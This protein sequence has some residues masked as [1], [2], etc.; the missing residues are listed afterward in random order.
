MKSC[1]LA[2]LSVSFLAVLALIGCN[3]REAAGWQGYL[4][5]DFVYVASPLAGRLEQLAVQKG[6]RIEAGARLFSLEQVNEIAAQREAADRLRSAQARLEDL[7]K[8]SRPSE[9]ATLEARLDQAR[10]A[11]ELSK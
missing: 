10:S 11:A 2:N 4:E 9:L 7:K 3:R 1:F 8:G 6:A 5:G